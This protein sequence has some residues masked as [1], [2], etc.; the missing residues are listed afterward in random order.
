MAKRRDISRLDLIAE[1]KRLWLAL[2]YNGFSIRDVGEAV[3]I[4]SASVHHHFPT[5]GDLAAAVLHH[6]RERWNTT[7]SAIA[8]EH[9]DWPT[10][11][12]A[13][14][15]AF[16][17][18]R[19]ATAVLLALA[20]ADF[21]TLSVPAKAEAQLWHENLIGW[22]ARFTTEASKRDELATSIAPTE[23]ALMLLSTLQGSLLL[24]RIAGDAAYAPGL[25]RLRQLLK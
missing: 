15:A 3:G 1:A 13:V 24:S 16:S 9:E 23:M 11:I 22:L 14:L 17:P 12:E 10:R 18:S 25:N 20:G 4:A 6:C 2:G 5:K 19:T 8:A 7:L 21:A